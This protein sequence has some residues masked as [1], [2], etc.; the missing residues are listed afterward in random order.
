MGIPT[1]W[2]PDTPEG[3]K[4]WLSVGLRRIP[5]ELLHS[6]ELELRKLCR[7]Q[8]CS[9]RASALELLRGLLTSREVL[10]PSEPRLSLYSTK[11]ELD[12]TIGS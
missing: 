12:S 7:I 10:R 8:K 6:I 3:L 1:S 11:N 4:S 9:G 2:D 5:A